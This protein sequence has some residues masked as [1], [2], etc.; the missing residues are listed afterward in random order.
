MISDTTSLVRFATKL[1]HFQW[2]L[3]LGFVI[4]AIIL[5]IAILGNE[6]NYLVI[7]AAGGAVLLAIGALYAQ[8][9]R[10]QVDRKLRSVKDRP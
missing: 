3:L 6:D 9:V 1:R 7:I 4:F 2:A 5:V 10:V 8:Y